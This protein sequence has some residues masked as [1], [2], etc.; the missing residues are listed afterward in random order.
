MPKCR[1]RRICREPAYTVFQNE[2]G[3]EEDIWLSADEYEAIRLIDREGFS[4]SACAERMNV[5]RT[6]AQLIYNS[7]RKKIADSIVLGKALR[8]GG[9]NY[10]VCDGSL[11]CTDCYRNVP[12]KQ[13]CESKGDSIMRIAVTYEDGNVFQHFGKT[14]QFKIYD[15]EGQQI[16]N[17][18]VV[19]TNGA[20]H[21]ALAGFLSANQV[22]TLICG[23]IGGGA[24]NALTEAKITL[25]AG[26]SG[27]TDKVVESYLR[28][29]LVS[30]DVTCHHHEHEEGHSC[31]EHGCGKH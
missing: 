30:A 16:K 3:S 23:G 1:K 17:S 27:N 28:G 22:D 15:V 12:V 19:D 8:I 4:Q 18:Q 2:E 20:G 24:K 14:A 9:G 21:G 26:A 11:R 25:C 31:G 29:E 5:A 7:A 13:V 6:T 10:A